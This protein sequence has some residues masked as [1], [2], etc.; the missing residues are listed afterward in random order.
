MVGNLAAVAVAVS[1]V[2][3]E[4]I[5]RA[6]VTLPLQRTEP[7]VSYPHRTPYADSR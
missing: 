6:V 3:A 5:L 7:E 1:V 4:G 2:A